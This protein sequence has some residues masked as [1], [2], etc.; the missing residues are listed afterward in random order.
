[1]ETR[2]SV[3][4]RATHLINP[5]AFAI[6]AS[7]ASMGLS[8]CT[9][10]NLGT[11]LPNRHPVVLIKGGPLQGSM[12]PYNAQI[13]WSGWDEDGVVTHY[14]YAVDPPAAFSQWEIAFPE[15]FPDIHID[16][17]PPA[18][19]GLPVPGQDTLVV[20]KLVDG[21]RASFRWVETHELSRSFRFQTPHPDSEF[22]NGGIEPKDQYS[23]SHVVYVRCQDNEGAFSDADPRTGGDTLEADYIGYTAT[24]QTPSSQLVLPAARTGFAVL[25]STLYAEWKGTDPDAPG[26]DK[27]PQGFLYNLVRL[28]RLEPPIPAL[29]AAPDLLNRFGHWTYQSRDTLK[30][31]LELGVPGEYIFGIRAVDIAGAVE[32]VLQL[33]RNVIKFQALARGGRPTLLVREPNFGT[34]Y[35]RGIGEP[36]EFQV[37]ANRTLKF[38]WS[39]IPDSTVGPILGF[40]WG[41]D[42]ADLSAEG[43]ESGW[44]GWSTLQAPPFPITFRAPGIHVLYVRVKDV[45]G[46]ITLATLILHAIE[47]TFDKEVLF[48]DDYMDN[49][50]P[51]DSEHDAFWDDMISSYVAES[52]L[53]QDQFS[54]FEVFGKNDRG[55]MLPII[56]FLSYVASYK[57][58]IWDNAGWGYSSDS[59][60]FRSTIMYPLLASYLRAGGKLWIIGSATV[61]AVTPAGADS[62]ADLVYPIRTLHPGNWAWD[63]LKLHS[64]MIN[65]DKGLI[66][67][68][69]MHGVHPISG[70]PAYYDSM[71]VDLTKLNAYQQI[72]GGFTHADAVFDPIYDEREPGFRGDIDS[73][74]AYGAA[75][76]EFQNQPSIYQDK[77]CGLRWHDP[78]PL[79]QH[80]R[81]QWFGFELYYFQRS[82]AVQVFK[83]SL[84]WLREETP[85]TP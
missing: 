40:S 31:L 55:N 72:Y 35:F 74:Y 23:G 18:P 10:E 37:P 24:T 83:Q 46:S 50:A 11:R 64:S 38:T 8:A 14:E 2:E 75:G 71:V 73:L 79:R 21:A 82:Q 78:D 39:G 42:L 4:G 66:R 76:P 44:S 81:V 80:G 9:E 32:P 47:F 27:S 70:V 77:L 61:S 65:N 85:P 25:G 22:V 33:G 7:L 52:G 34:A 13:F 69:L 3:R 57:L 19:S 48:V 59:G 26:F 45:G 1:M 15:R 54:R 20:S 17:I 56:P 28:D 36:Q 68:H 63:F 53:S 12:A 60:L 29:Y 62:M 30:T 43:S 51:R 49:L 67:E 84:D 5:F 58:L 6:L 16:L 41:L